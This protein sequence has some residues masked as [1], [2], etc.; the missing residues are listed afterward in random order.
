[1]AF[2]AELWER[3]L[4]LHGEPW[5]GQ[6]L[7]GAAEVGKTPYETIYREGSWR[8]LRYGAPA[9]ISEVA[10]VPL[11]MIPSLIN[12]FYILDLTPGKSLVAYLLQRGNEVYMVDWGIPGEEE[13]F[14]PF[15]A[16]AHHRIHR[17]IEAVL[18]DSGADEIS[19]LG[20][21]VGGTFATIY[22]A[23][24]PTSAVTNLINLAGPINFHDDGLLSQWT[25]AEWFNV[26]RL[27][28]TLGN[29]PPALLQQ[30]FR[31]LR[32]TG[33]WVRALRFYEL[34]TEGSEEK[35]KSFRAMNTWVND[36]V[37]FPGETF[38]FYI[39][40]LYQGN[41][42]LRDELR[43]A[44]RPVRLADIRAN[45]LTIAASQDHITPPTSATVLNQKVSSPDREVLLQPGGH[46]GI[47]AG[48]G[49]ERGLWPRLADWL[50]ARST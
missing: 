37:P 39:K 24:E 25:R 41:K 33:E 36:P 20:Y 46:I 11:L 48:S 15:A 27:V 10:A 8:V 5:A 7:V 3:W 43:V 50:L 13:R 26:D 40:E 45:L 21:C 19:L 17:A 4:P 2:W 1:M 44:G 47:V 30:A 35:L 23:I 31:M 32:P 38:R 6:R 16:Y 29:I 12:R 28:D 22:T 14:T 18:A 42:L 9:G 49:A 34:M